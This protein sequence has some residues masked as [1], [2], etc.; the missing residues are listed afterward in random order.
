M[1]G[2]DRYEKVSSIYGPGSVCCWFL[3]ACSVFVSWTLHPV[4]RDDDSITYDFITILAYAAVAGGHAIAQ[5][6]QFRGQLYKLLTSRDIEILKYSSALE[7]S[8]TIWKAFFWIFLSLWPIALARRQKKRFICFLAVSHLPF[9]VQVCLHLVL[10]RNLTEVNFYRPQMVYSGGQMII[11]MILL[12][13]FLGWAIFYYRYINWLFPYASL[14]DTRCWTSPPFVIALGVV[15]GHFPIFVNEFL[16]RS[17]VIREEIKLLRSM[18]PTHFIPKSNILLNELDQALPLAIG[19]MG[20]MYT[21]YDTLQEKRA[22]A[23]K[24]QV[25]NLEPIP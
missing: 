21:V 7:A 2:A 3:S 19:V 1:D 6:F 25:V 15:L 17:D 16:A 4:S 9:A 13:I 5:L 8:V 20:F 23:R 14:I 12:S 10:R 24:A 11:T 22:R 18:R